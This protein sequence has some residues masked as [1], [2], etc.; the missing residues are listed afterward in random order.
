M[1]NYKSHDPT[2]RL[3]GKLP[4]K[5]DRRNLQLSKYLIEL[6]EPPEEH[7]QTKGQENWGMMA[8]DRAGDCTCA[9]AGHPGA[10]ISR[11][12]AADS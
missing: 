7:D 9:A 11:R 12:A 3:M 10:P 1:K 8:N 5:E 6:P 4:K 2:R